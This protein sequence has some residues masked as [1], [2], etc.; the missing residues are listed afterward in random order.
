M[1]MEAV[2]GVLLGIGL[3]AACGFR[4]FVPLLVAAIAIRG[5]FLTV[6]PIFMAGGTRWSPSP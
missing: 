3:G 6:T 1:N 4:I 2:M 5:G